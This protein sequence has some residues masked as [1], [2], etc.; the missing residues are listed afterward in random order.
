MSSSSS[1]NL[2]INKNTSINRFTSGEIKKA[3][4]KSSM[5]IGHDIK[6]DLEDLEV[7]EEFK[8]SVFKPEGEHKTKIDFK[9]K[10]CKGS[11]LGNFFRRILG[12]KSKEMSP[13]A[14]CERKLKEYEKGIES[15]R[16]EIGKEK[17][18]VK[19]ESLGYL[20][21]VEKQIKSL[22]EQVANLKS[23]MAN[24][25]SQEDIT[26]GIEQLRKEIDRLPMNLERAR[27]VQIFE[28]CIS[29]ETGD[30]AA[31]IARSTYREL[32][33]SY[34]VTREGGVLKIQRQFHAN[35]KYANQVRRMW[36]GEVSPERGKIG[37]GGV[38]EAHKVADIETGK[39]EVRGVVIRGK[40]QQQAIEAAKA[41]KGKRHLCLGN[42]LRYTK[43]Y[44]SGGKVEKEVFM[45]PFME[46]GDALALTEKLKGRTDELAQ[47]IR[48]KAMLQMAMGVKDVHDE[49]WCH[50][51]IK[52]DNFFVSGSDNPD[53]LDVRLADF[54]FAM[55]LGMADGIRDQRGSPFTMAPEIYDRTAMGSEGGK[56]ADIYSLGMTLWELETGDMA[57]FNETGPNKFSPPE[58]IIVLQQRLSD[59]G[60]S[61]NP[62]ERTPLQNLII[63]M[64]NPDPNQ[65]P[66]IDQVITELQQIYGMEQSADKTPVSKVEEQSTK[67]VEPT[68]RSIEEA[69]EFKADFNREKAESHLKEMNSPGKYIIWPPSTPGY[70]VFSY[71]DENRNIQHITLAKGR[72]PG[73]IY[74]VEREVNQVTT[75]DKFLKTHNERYHR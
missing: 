48:A 55:K 16:K 13:L 17:S 15:Q 38:K 68:L 39:I 8:K 22:R 32:T 26:T 53:T 33:W 69:A 37:E 14:E 75:I 28:K 35:K 1:N 24:E 59:N 41:L 10:S 51:D 61:L 72:R 43:K 6:Q 4:N 27:V 45:S 73:E 74:I 19:D 46:E 65:R 40:A 63:R 23:L 42:F 25:E 52:V 5:A 70:F 3:E 71:L 30:F 18:E 54:D 64:I 56:K 9:A 49:G 21:G 20:S 36:H 47:K 12:I 50:L 31:H 34:I 44:K 60:V 66:T 58:N 57:P 7:L 62:A 29:S 2:G 11:K 67:V